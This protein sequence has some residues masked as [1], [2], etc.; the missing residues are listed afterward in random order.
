MRN[1]IDIAT[2]YGGLFKYLAEQAAWVCYAPNG[3]TCQGETKEEAA[4]AFCEQFE[5]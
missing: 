5:L 4:K 1:Y 3:Q 2:S